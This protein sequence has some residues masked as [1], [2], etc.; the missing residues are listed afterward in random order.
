MLYQ[1]LFLPIKTTG[2]VS[3]YTYYIYFSIIV[4]LSI[5]STFFFMKSLLRGEISRN[6]IYIIYI[7]IYYIISSMIFYQEDTNLSDKFTICAAGFLISIYSFY[8]GSKLITLGKK[9]KIDALVITLL[10]YFV[11]F[12][13]TKTLTYGFDSLIRERYFIYQSQ[14]MIFMV[15]WI[16]DFSSLNERWKILFNLAIMI[17]VLIT[18]SRSLLIGMILYIF[19]KSVFCDQNNKKIILSSIILFSLFT[20]FLI[21]DWKSIDLTRFYGARIKGGFFTDNYRDIIRQEYI[22]HVINNYFIGMF[23]SG[24]NVP[25]IVTGEQHG[26]TIIS[27]HNFYLYLISSVGMLGT[28]TLIFFG[29]KTIGIKK[30]IAFLSFMLIFSFANDIL[31]FPSYS[32]QLL[33]LSVWY[34]I[35]GLYANKT[36]SCRS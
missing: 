13:I 4:Y 2:E 29:K 15:F 16:N 8:L 17:P 24:F 27:P 33:K 5:L 9:N 31:I 10:S 26:F 23:G 7:Y 28:L 22:K 11:V 12:T 34:L 19:I 35:F 21:F 6:M 32:S 36:S 30:N 14:L 18:G 20:G 3:N 1:I 25:K